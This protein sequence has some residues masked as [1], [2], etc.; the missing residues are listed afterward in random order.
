MTWSDSSPADNVQSYEDIDLAASGYI[1]VHVQ[2]EITWDAGSSD[3]ADVNIYGSA[4]SGT[5]IDT[6]AIS[7][8]RIEDDPGNTTKL[9]FL[10][11]NLPYIRVEVDNQSNAEISSLVGQFAGLKY[12]SA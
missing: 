7:S 6:I 8:Q 11:E 3:Y 1:A 10:V 12:S 4:N 5:D 2:I 9:S